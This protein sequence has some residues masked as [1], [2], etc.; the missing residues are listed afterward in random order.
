[1]C[2]VMYMSVYVFT[3]ILKKCVLYVGMC[4]CF[5][6]VDSI[7]VWEVFVLLSRLNDDWG[8]GRS[9]RSGESG[10]IPLMI[11]EDV[12]REGREG[13]RE[14]LGGCP[15]CTVHTNRHACTATHVYYT[16]LSDRR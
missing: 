13:G 5:C 1:M 8:W 3:C 10:L 2:T 4:L 7:D 11:M 15:E 16:L 12:V 9:Q 14:G 6:V